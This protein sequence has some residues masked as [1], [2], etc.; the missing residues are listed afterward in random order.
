MALP[1]NRAPA[2]SLKANELSPTSDQM[3]DPTPLPPSQGVSSHSGTPPGV[4]DPGPPGGKGAG[5][6]PGPPAGT[7]P[8][9]PEGHAMGP[10]EGH[11]AGPPPGMDSG[12]PRLTME[13]IKYFWPFVR[14]HRSKLIGVTLLLVLV[15]IT[16]AVFGYMPRWMTQNWTPERVKT[17]WWIL[18]GLLGLQVLLTGVQF[19]LMWW[20]AQISQGFTHSTRL[21]VF[22]KLGR[23]SSAVLHRESIGS[24][25]QRSTSD[26]MR[27]QDWLT[28]QVP[29]AFANVVQLFATLYALF[30]LGTGFILLA[31]ALTPLVAFILKLLNRRLSILAR[32]C[33]V[34]SERIMTQFIEGAAGYRDLVASGRYGHAVKKTDAELG[35]LRRDAIRMSMA[36]YLTGVIPATTFTLL[37]YAYYYVKLGDASLAGDVE[38]LG[39]VLAF[40]GLFGSLQGPVMGISG[41]FTDSAIA[42]PSFLQLKRLLESPETSNPDTSIVPGSGSIELKNVTFSHEPGMPPILD[43]LSCTIEAGKF[44]A[45]VGQTGSG[46]TTLFHLLLR[47]IEPQQ[48][49]VIVG[50]EDLSRISL[51]ILRDFVGFIPQA[52]FLFDATLKENILLGSGGDPGVMERL[53]NA[54]SLARLD[55]LVETRASQ[56]G[57]EAPVGPQ[58]VTLSGG[59]RQRVALAR[60]FLRDP[61]IIVCDEYTA[62]IDNAT[63]R[64]IQESLAREFAGRTRVVISHQLYTVRGADRILILERGRII[65]S[66]THEELISRPGLYRDLWEVQRID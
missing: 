27:V 64:I 25:A 66:G 61:Q 8:G 65:D 14:P 59:E 51:P 46:K 42:A 30:T 41:F 37:I 24:I 39:K 22:E 34:R 32:S 55:H 31:L 36:G 28:P 60:V 35:G 50:G 38:Y 54:V 44:T 16:P 5:I 26:V 43:N 33:Q 56:G 49:R 17:L 47:L 53:Q 29:Q 20:T 15:G 63:A 52:P 11:D 10:P 57:L 23:M 21:A 13:V 1:P 58:G 6:D 2:P 7:D 4:H 12:P 62:N 18:G 19:L 48:G 40:A 45:V 9:P 3:T